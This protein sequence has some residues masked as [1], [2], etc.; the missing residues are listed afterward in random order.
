[1]RKY[2]VLALSLLAATASSSAW[3]IQFDGFLTAGGAVSDE[4]TTGY[5]GTINDEISFETDS[6]FG[7]QITSE[8]AEDTTVVAQI[9]GA[10]ANGNFDAIVEWAY[11]DYEFTDNLSLRAGKIKEPVFLISDYVEVGY[12]Y[13]WIRPPA[14]VYSNNPLNTVNGMELFLQYPVG[15]NTLSLQAYLGSNSEDIP[16][17]GGFGQFEAINIS[18]VDVKFSGRGY[19]VHASTLQTDVNTQ[20]SLTTGIGGGVMAT[21]DLNATGEAELTSFGFNLDMANVVV[22]AEAQEREIRGGVS[23]LFADQESSYVTVGYR[24]GKWLPHVTVA[25]IEGSLTGSTVALSCASPTGCGGPTTFGS[26]LGGA[27]FPFAEQDSTTLGVRYELNDS[28]ALKIEHQ[29]IE[30]ATMNYGLFQVSFDQAAPPLPPKDV[31][32]TSIALDVIF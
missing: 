25:T 21:V 31:A 19:V 11:V 22:Y 2:S 29:M 1:M 13:P 17:T 5:L 3:A 27:A 32:I 7:L 20:G 24:M 15:Q 26:P 18:G 4:A 14:E 12:A 16:N 6:R 10:G 9:L 8:I 28:A 30:P 23:A